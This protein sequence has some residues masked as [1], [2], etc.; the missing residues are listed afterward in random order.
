MYAI[1]TRWK[2]VGGDKTP[3]PCPFVQSC[4]LLKLVLNVC[5]E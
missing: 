5:M 2:L 4:F 1:A 3:L